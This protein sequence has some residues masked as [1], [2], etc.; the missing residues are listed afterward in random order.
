M[1]AGELRERVTFEKRASADDGYGNT[2]GAWAAQ[3][4]VSAR[5]RMLRGT[6]TVMA[7]RLS[8]VQPV[9]VTV[10]SETRTR[11]LTPDWRLVDARVGTV[12]NIR[13]VTPDERKVFIDLLCDSGVA[14]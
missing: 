11:A 8:G 5:I 6:E 3:F 9:V 12:Y 7:Q 13:T 14:T 4:S 1:P 10:Y 2:Q